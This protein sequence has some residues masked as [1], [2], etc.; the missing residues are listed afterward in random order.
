MESVATPWRQAP[1]DRAT[2]FIVDDD[3]ETREA[4]AILARAAHLDAEP[5]SSAYAFLE[6]YHPRK[7]G[8]LVLDVCMPGIS[9]IELHQHLVERGIRL[10][11]IFVSG[12]GEVQTAA[13]AMR[14]GAIDFLSKPF[15][16]DVLLERIQ[17]A[18]RI[19]R[20]RREAERRRKTLD[21]RI[22]TLTHRESEVMRLLALGQTTKTIAASLGISSKTVD[23]HRIKVLEKMG[24]DNA[25]QLSRLLLHAD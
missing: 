21:A 25:T 20:E 1:T 13:A 10:P 16:P 24:V 11:V 6:A 14:A 9:G 4:I 12:H 8:C 5:C 15:C 2:V 18:I 17:E 3:A 19:D 7:T 23:N 22:A